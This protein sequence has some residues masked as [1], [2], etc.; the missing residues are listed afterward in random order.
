V[1][2]VIAHVRT[3]HVLI[4]HARPY[5][6]RITGLYGYIPSIRRLVGS[7]PNVAAS[8]GGAFKCYGDVAFRVK[9]AVWGAEGTVQ[10]PAV[11]E[12]ADRRTGA[13]QR[14]QQVAGVGV[15][16]QRRQGAQQ[17]PLLVPKVRLHDR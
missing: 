14:A 8:Q 6:A 11:S 16:V 2:Y 10:G 3:L 17:F 9:W 7:H 15:E 1:L 12:S 13:S 5:S 4:I